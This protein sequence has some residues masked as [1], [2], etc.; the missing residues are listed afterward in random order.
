M[1]IR[2][3][4]SARGVALWPWTVTRSSIVLSSNKVR[5]HKARER[6]PG[7]WRTQTAK[8]LDSTYR[9]QGREVIRPLRNLSLYKWS[10]TFS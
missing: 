5:Q 3:D 7:M 8:L 9:K 1:N 4:A 10:H 2:L 6:G